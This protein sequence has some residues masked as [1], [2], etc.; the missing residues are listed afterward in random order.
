MFTRHLFESCFNCYWLRHAP[1]IIGTLNHLLMYVFKTTTRTDQQWLLWNTF[2]CTSMNLNLSWKKAEVRWVRRNFS[3][4]FLL[5]WLT[6]LST[7]LS[8]SLNSRW[9]SYT[10]RCNHILRGTL[11][12][13]NFHELSNTQHMCWTILKGENS[14]QWQ[15]CQHGWFALVGL[16][17]SCCLD[18]V[19]ML[20]LIMPKRSRNWS[21]G[22]RDEKAK[23][24]LKGM[25]KWRQLLLTVQRRL[26][27][28]FS[29][30]RRGRV[31][32]SIRAQPQCLIKCAVIEWWYRKAK[33]YSREWNG[34]HFSQAVSSKRID[35][36]S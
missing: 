27:S 18:S 4:W 34:V 15:K 31:N 25:L 22:F 29:S 17:F 16:S 33:S 11:S 19:S 9:S 13:I 6:Y 23:P 20:V 35:Q 14:S 21:P 3:A 24:R 30:R 12:T 1:I 8:Y 7:S 10:R 36:V 5:H 28:F 2:W 32:A 26:H